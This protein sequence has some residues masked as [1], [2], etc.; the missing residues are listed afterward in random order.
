MGA[1]TTTAFGAKMFGRH[2]RT[3]ITLACPSWA[4]ARRF[5]LTIGSR[6]G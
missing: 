2:Q 3:V 4:K 5:A 6:S 1:A